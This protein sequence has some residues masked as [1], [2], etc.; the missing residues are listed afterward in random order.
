MVRLRNA[1]C[2]QHCQEY[3]GRRL[4]YGF[5]DVTDVEKTFREEVRRIEFDPPLHVQTFATTSVPPWTSAEG[6]RSRQ[7]DEKVFSAS[8]RSKCMRNLRVLHCFMLLLN[9]IGMGLFLLD[10][11]W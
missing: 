11:G 1:Q 8:M 6:N 4:R 10:T 7:L 2:E 3:Y 5:D 9:M